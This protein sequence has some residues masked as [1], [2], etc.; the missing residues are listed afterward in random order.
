M[1]GESFPAVSPLNDGVAGDPDAWRGP[2]RG[3]GESMWATHKAEGLSVPFWL[4]AGFFFAG[5]ERT[6]FSNMGWLVTGYTPRSC[7]PLLRQPQA[8]SSIFPDAR[9]SDDLRRQGDHAGAA[10]M[11][12]VVSKC[13]HHEKETRPL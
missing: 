12:N 2:C 7:D 13:A 11:D 3:A 5:R 9:L 4:S 10:V 6:A 1:E 8:K